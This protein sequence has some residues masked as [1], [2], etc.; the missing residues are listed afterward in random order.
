MVFRHQQEKG[1]RKLGEVKT[2]N[3]NTLVLLQKKSVNLGKNIT[4]TDKESIGISIGSKK[5]KESQVLIMSE[6]IFFTSLIYFN[7][8][9][10]IILKL[11]FC[12]ER[13]VFEHI[14]YSQDNS[15]EAVVEITVGHLLKLTKC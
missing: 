9:E 8:S 2:T 14:S 12:L 13:T 7:C 3:T 1:Y 11:L 4:H 5:Q 10:Y 6:V 15:T